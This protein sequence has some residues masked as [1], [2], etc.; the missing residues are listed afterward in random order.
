MVKRVSVSIPELI[1]LGFTR[2]LIGIGIGLFL[3]NKLTRP[4]R[5]AIGLPLFLVGALSTIPIAFSVFRNRS[6]H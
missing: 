3:A 4:R 1:L 6:R 5:K 2:G